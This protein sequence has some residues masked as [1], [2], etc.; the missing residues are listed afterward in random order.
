MNEAVQNCDRSIVKF[1]T[2]LND[3]KIKLTS[4]TQKDHHVNYTL[5][6]TNA[7]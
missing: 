2:R 7:A 4:Q 1:T 6:I 3:S 5:Q